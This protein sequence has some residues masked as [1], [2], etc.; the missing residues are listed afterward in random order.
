MQDLV[1]LARAYGIVPEGGAVVPGLGEASADTLTAV[2]AS[3]GVDASSPARIDVALT[4]AI[5]DEWRRMLPLFVTCIEGQARTFYVHVP[6]GSSVDVHVELEDGGRA[7]AYQVDNFEPPRQVDGELTGRAEFKVENLPIGYH[8]IVARSG[9][10]T[11]RTT[12]L[13]SPARLDLPNEQQLWGLMAQAYSVRSHLSWGI[14]DFADLRDLMWITGRKFHGDFVLVN[15]THA[16]EPIAPLTP[17]PYLPSSRRYLNPIY[18]RVEDI[19][20]TAYLVSQ[21]RSLVEWQAE[22]A[23]ALNTEPGPIDRD[24]VWDAKKAA[25]EV[26]FH[27]RR[28]PARELEYHEFVAEHGEPL[29]TFALWC[30]LVERHGSFELPAEYASPKSPAVV[31]LAAELAPRIEFYQWL[32]WIADQQLAAVQATAEDCGMSIG[33]MADLAVGVHESGADAWSLADVLVPTVAVGSP[34]DYYNQQGQNWSQPPWHP[35]ELAKASF[36]PFREM[37]RGVLR[38]AGAVRID[39]VIG[40][41]RTWWI[42]AGM[43]PRQGVYVR[44]DHEALIGILLL[45]AKR[46]GAMVI[47]EDL[48]IVEP[49]VREYLANRG[50]LGTSVLWFE[51]DYDGNWIRPEHYR[52]L[53]LATVTTHDLPPTAG[54]LAGE[55]VELRARLGLLDQPVEWERQQAAQERA[56]VVEMLAE[57]GLVGDDP[58]EREI[59]EALHV[60]LRSAPSAL[61]GVALTDAVGERRTQ[62]QPGTDTEYPNWKIPLSDSA[63]NLVFIEDLVTNQ[64]LRSLV[65][66]LTPR[67]R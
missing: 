48:G 23:R 10:T 28:S 44:H 37:V 50:V 46:A 27:A 58:S 41:F 49:W 35:I 14:G 30:A 33:L 65:A 25:L 47:G 59:V 66:A 24:A 56:E 4:N 17:S 15:P 61:L 40:M 63:Q 21:D 54:Y 52:K 45:E 32:Q 5:D 55:H 8:Q 64:R 12:L 67:G 3:L 38:H 39:H 26:V 2:L 1:T 31:K 18:I 36:A 43:T 11:A 34:P 9:S 29:A 6:D 60:Y 42:P 51:K 57:R 20:E 22:P 16:G 13:V 62:N 53:A 7:E 19:P